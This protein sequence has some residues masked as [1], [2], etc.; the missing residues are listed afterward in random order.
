MSALARFYNSQGKKVSGYDL[1][2][3]KLTDKL[4]ASGINIHYTIDVDLIP[5]DIDLVI[6]TPAIPK[7]HE[8]LVKL[9]NS[10]IPVIKRSMALGQLSKSMDCIA[11]AGT[12]GKTST[13]AIL[14]H[15][16]VSGG[17]DPTAFVGGIIKNYNS[18]YI[19]GSSNWFI[20]VVSKDYHHSKS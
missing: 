11:V 14:A 2:Q 15:L 12:H 7:D 13:S 6:Y 4:S 10:D 20:A 3:T 1:T 5:E 18:N 8:E 17:L 9:Q 19:E 16:M